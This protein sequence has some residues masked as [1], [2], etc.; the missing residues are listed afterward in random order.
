M[1]IYKDKNL[2][3]KLIS[4]PGLFLDADHPCV[5]MKRYAKDGKSIFKIGEQDAIKLYT[6]YKDIWNSEITDEFG[7]NVYN[8]KE[9]LAG[10][11]CEENLK[12]TIKELFD[13]R[14]VEK[15][16]LKDLAQKKEG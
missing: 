10:S 3:E 6:Y 12:L 13:A 1:V 2:Y 15:E 16:L 9:V 11:Y 14:E 5:T 4:H 8:F 7:D